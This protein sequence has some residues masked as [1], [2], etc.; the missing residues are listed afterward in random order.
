MNNNNSQESFEKEGLNINAEAISTSLT[1]A[2][3]QIPKLSNYSAQLKTV[4]I[5]TFTDFYDR[6]NGSN[7]NKAEFE[8]N[9]AEFEN[10]F[11]AILNTDGTFDKIYNNI[12][13]KDELKAQIDALIKKD[14][15]QDS[16]VNKL[17]AK[18]KAIEQ[19]PEADNLQQ[20][21]EDL[22]ADKQTQDK[23]IT[24]L[25]QQIE[26]L[27]VDKQK[28]E[29]QIQDLKA[30]K[31]TQEQ[32]ITVLQQQIEGL[33]QPE[34]LDKKLE[35]QAI[36]FLKNMIENVKKEALKQTKENENQKD[37]LLT[38]KEIKKAF[39]EKCQKFLVQMNSNIDAKNQ[40]FLGQMNSNID[41]KNQEI[42]NTDKNLA[43]QI[44]NIKN[45]SDKDLGLV[46]D[47]LAKKDQK[48]DTTEDIS[49][50]NG[51]LLV[52]ASCIQYIA[53]AIAYLPDIAIGRLTGKEYESFKESDYKKN[54]KTVKFV[55]ELSKA[56]EGGISLSIT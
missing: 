44:M 28:Q 48:I 51:W 42:K 13:K 55:D 29:Q 14:L 8:K 16:I 56:Q 45:F 12:K 34:N 27:E 7:A 41:G 53:R 15:I 40:E 10:N 46:Y 5:K 30:E 11:I 21:I 38:D 6:A 43:T 19:A 31:Q 49:K 23:Q 52:I 25:K 24:V 4:V 18:T 20:Q 1:D 50:D 35:R 3:S 22:K 36:T 37:P 54:I 32:Q 39:V 9:K 2:Y 33:R 47:V 17:K 26:G